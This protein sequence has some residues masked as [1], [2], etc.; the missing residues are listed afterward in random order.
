M[1]HKKLASEEA[2]VAPKGAGVSGN[3]FRY[4]VI[5]QKRLVTVKFGNRLTEDEIASYV[6]S[7]T[8][9]PLFDPKFSEIVDLSDVKKIDLRGEQ[10]LKLA[11]EVDP[12]SFDSKRAF[13]VTDV[14]Q[15]HAARM[16]QILRTSA[17]KIRTFYSVVEA[18]R[19]IRS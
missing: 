7:V 4:Q 12:F 13:V 17:D 3:R 15:T 9:D 19:W 18:E 6:A 14:T 16:H 10:M 1:F 11:D 8:A 2:A 5:P